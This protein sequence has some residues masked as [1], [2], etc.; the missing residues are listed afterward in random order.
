MKNSI[1]F[2]GHQDHGN[3]DNVYAIVEVPCDKEINPDLLFQQKALILY[4]RRN[5]KLR[6]KTIQGLEC[7][8]YRYRAVA[9]LDYMDKSDLYKTKQFAKVREQVEKH[10]FWE[11]LKA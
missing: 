6:C 10:L 3:S 1:Y 4:G 11:M 5:G 9:E 8:F 7:S 2:L